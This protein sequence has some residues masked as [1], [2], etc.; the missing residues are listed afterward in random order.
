MKLA[1]SGKGGVGKTTPTATLAAAQALDGHQVIAIDADPD[2]NLGSAL[3]IVPEESLTPLAEVRD[4]IR[5]P[6]GAK[7]DYGGFFKLNPK[8]DDLPDRFSRRVGNVRLLVL[9]GIRRGGEG[10]QCPASALLKAL[11]IHLTIG[12][13][14]ALLMD[15]EAGIEHLGRATA[16]SM[17]A[18]LVVVDPSPWSIHTAQGVHRLAADVGMGNLPAVANRTDEKQFEDIRQRLG[19]IRLVGNLPTDEGL[20]EGILRVAEPD[21]IERSD[22]VARHLPTL[23]QMPARIRGD[24]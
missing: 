2:A 17:D 8:V 20:Y 7:N 23:R 1:I 24:P 16:E 14:T 12:S 15:M 22:A 11:L 13:D 5:E 19:D 4:L 6:T 18:L 10:C 3:G 9:G 21:R